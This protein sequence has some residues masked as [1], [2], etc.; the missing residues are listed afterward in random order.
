MTVIPV[1]RVLAMPQRRQRGSG[2]GVAPSGPI[3]YCRTDGND[4]NT[5]LTNSAG[6]AWQTARKA[7][8]A[9]VPGDTLRFVH[10]GGAST[11]Y[12][13]TAG[14]AIDW[15]TAP[16]GGFGTSWAA[17]Q[18]IRIEAN[19][20]D[21]GKIVLKRDTAAGSAVA[22][23]RATSAA[24]NV[25]FVEFYNL[26][27][28]GLKNSNA[29]NTYVPLYI[30]A[31]P[32]TDN[33]VHDIRFNGSECKNSAQSSGFLQESTTTV[34]AGIPYNLLFT[35][36]VATGR[37]GKLTNN[38]VNT[39]QHGCYMQGRNNEVSWT[40]ISGNMGLGLQV[41]RDASGA[42]NCNDIYIHHVWSHGNGSSGFYYG[43]GARGKIHNCLAHDN[44]THGIRFD[45]GATD[46]QALNCTSVRNTT[47]NF[48]TAATAAV[49]GTIFTNCVAQKLGV[50]ASNWADNGSTATITTC[51]NVALVDTDAT[52]PLFVNAAADNFHLQSGSPC[53]DTGTD[54]SAQGITDDLDGTV[55]SGTYDQGAYEFV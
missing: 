52:D 24:L 32:R 50:S 4:A 46:G 43:R 13:E 40:E 35:I 48:T 10:T 21:E 26:I 53:R 12:V 38:G 55:R 17:N 33:T 36:D 31:S 11:E 25:Q 16:A 18:R 7:A 14:P 54:L 47:A 41:H 6:G 30:N 37:W 20:G 42:D 9:L 39:Q 44:G 23:L 5:G 1:G 29:T 15:S 19:P 28:D 22:D 34:G 3:Y 27:F 45:D 8:R 2:I 51:T 49:T